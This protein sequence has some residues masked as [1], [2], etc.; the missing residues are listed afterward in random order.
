MLIALV[1][2]FILVGCGSQSPEDANTSLAKKRI[3]QKIETAGM[4]MIDDIKIE[5]IT[6]IND[7]TY[8][9]AHSFTNPMFSKEIR[10][11]KEY[12]FTKDLESITG[13]KDVKAEMK[14]EG[15]WVERKF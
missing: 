11:T 6:K 7:T 12:Y 10:I 1:V 2:S 5:S 15:E 14:S 9:A 13:D 4:G 8:K 3:I